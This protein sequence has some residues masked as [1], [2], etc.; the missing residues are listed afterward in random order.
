MDIE[1][2]KA[3]V[4]HLRA[5]VKSEMLALVIKRTQIDAGNNAHILPKNKG[6]WEVVWHKAA[7]ECKY[8]DADLK[9]MMED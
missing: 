4:I 7:E 8:C 9:V 2:P 5:N 3:K 6:R 1:L